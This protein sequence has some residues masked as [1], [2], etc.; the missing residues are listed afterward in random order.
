[1]PVADRVRSEVPVVLADFPC[2]SVPPHVVLVVALL[3][4]DLPLSV[5]AHDSFFQL[6][7]LF[8]GLIMSVT[9][10]LLNFYHIFGVGLPAYFSMA[11]F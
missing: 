10:F 6:S 11:H 1:M 7:P 4:V 9:I 5:I 8:A 2:L 3:S